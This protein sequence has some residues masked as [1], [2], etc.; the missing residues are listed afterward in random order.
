MPIE[1]PLRLTTIE[2]RCPPPNEIHHHEAS[3]L[4]HRDEGKMACWAG[5]WRHPVELG[6]LNPTWLLSP[7]PDAVE[8]WDKLTDQQK[9]CFDYLMSVD[10]AAVCV[11]DC[12]RKQSARST[13]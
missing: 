12:C 13:G 6:L 10:A 9:D 5:G 7:R 1:T 11:L 3:G 4:F 8:A 2:R